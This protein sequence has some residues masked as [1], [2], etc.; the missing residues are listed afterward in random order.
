MKSIIVPH[1]P[2]LSG[3]Q[4]REAR[5]DT[6]GNKRHD[7]DNGYELGVHHYSCPQIVLASRS[8]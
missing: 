5:A 2:H 7:E 8:T 3:E 6:G 4:D 1:V